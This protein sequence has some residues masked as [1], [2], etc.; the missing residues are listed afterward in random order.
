MGGMSGA[1]FVCYRQAKDAQLSGTYRAFIT[2]K[3]QNLDSVV[4]RTEDKKIPVVNAKV[5]SS[6]LSNLLSNF[7]C[8]RKDVLPNVQ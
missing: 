6:H 1:D 3:T 5:S 2:S 7:I 8:M 4:H